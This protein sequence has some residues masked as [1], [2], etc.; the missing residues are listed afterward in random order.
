MHGP[1][2]TVHACIRAVCPC[3]LPY[4]DCCL[5]YDGTRTLTSGVQGLGGGEGAGGGGASRRSPDEFYRHV[6]GAL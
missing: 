3:K 1:S 2:S 6:K 5:V 4:P